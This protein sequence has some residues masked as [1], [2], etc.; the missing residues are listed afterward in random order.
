MA[1]LHTSAGDTSFGLVRIM[2]FVMSAHD[3]EEFVYDID[4]I[5]NNLSPITSNNIDATVERNDRLHIPHLGC[6]K[7]YTESVLKYELSF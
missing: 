2:P 1:C 3:E 6:H 5:V 4:H 7:Y